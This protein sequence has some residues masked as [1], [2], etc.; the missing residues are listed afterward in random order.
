LDAHHSNHSRAVPQRGAPKGSREGA[1]CERSACV[2]GQLPPRVL[3][4]TLGAGPVTAAP[5]AT[6]QSTW[7]LSVPP[8]AAGNGPL[9]GRQQQE[10]L[11]KDQTSILRRVDWISPE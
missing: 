7:C 8:L 3:L 2:W 10:V 5:G 4:P 1:T 9:A 11:A 6:R